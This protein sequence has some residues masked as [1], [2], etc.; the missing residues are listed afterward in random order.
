MVNLLELKLPEFSKKIYLG[1]LER[2]DVFVSRARISGARRS[3]NT[4]TSPASAG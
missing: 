1:L 4:I 2:R 3:R